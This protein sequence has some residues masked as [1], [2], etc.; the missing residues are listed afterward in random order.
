MRRH[1][2]PKAVHEHT[3]S[4][5][6]II[7][8]IIITSL[9]FFRLSLFHP[10]SRWTAVRRT[11]L[12]VDRRPLGPA[13]LRSFNRGRFLAGFPRGKTRRSGAS[14]NGIIDVHERSRGGAI[15]TGP[16]QKT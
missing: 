12:P 13:S 16:E 7:I 11:S 1:T 9:F 6:N 2:I 3:S 5:A 14:Y 4:R 8:I 10:S 15:G